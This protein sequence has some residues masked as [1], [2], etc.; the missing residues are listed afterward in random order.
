MSM[1]GAHSL[2]SGV[3]SKG[4]C[5]S[6]TSAMVGDL[7]T[8]QIVKQH[9]ARN[10]SSGWLQHRKRW[11][12]LHTVTLTST[13]SGRRLAEKQSWKMCVTSE[14]TCSRSVLLCMLIDDSPFE[15]TSVSSSPLNKFGEFWQEHGYF[16]ELS[17]W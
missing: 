11:I 6:E 2:Q 10:A 1:S 14:D 16:G 12:P 9:Q 17:A 13:V 3:F 7:A 15:V 8:G 4:G 5:G